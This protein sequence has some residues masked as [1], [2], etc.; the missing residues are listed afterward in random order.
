MAGDGHEVRYETSG[1]PNAHIVL[2]GG[3]NGPNFDEV[4]I[5]RCESE[6]E[7]AGLKQ[8]IMV[9][10]SHDNSC[11]NPDLQ[12]GVAAEVT[13]QIIAGNQSIIGMR[14]CNIGQLLS[15]PCIIMVGQHELR[16]II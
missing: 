6:L 10:C 5:N 11:K 14:F 1:N 9:D 16:H 15:K 4:S 12:P 3:S 7:K 2:R 13:R 8:N